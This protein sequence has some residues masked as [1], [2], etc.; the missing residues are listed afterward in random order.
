[1]SMS[2]GV[3]GGVFAT[4]ADLQASKP[5]VNTR[6]ELVSGVAYSIDSSDGGANL[7]VNGLFANPIPPI[8]PEHFGST[9]DGVADDGAA[10]QSA[11]G[12]S[13]E[14]EFNKTYFVGNTAGLTVSSNSSIKG[15]GTLKTNSFDANR[16]IF[17]LSSNNDISISGLSF[18]SLRNGDTIAVDNTAI[19]G[20]GCSNLNIKNITIENFGYYG[21]HLE[22]ATDCRLDRS[23]ITNVGRAG[24]LGLGNTRCHVHNNFIKDVSPGS[25]GVAPFIN[26]FGIVFS[27]TESSGETRSTFCSAIGN[28]IENVD[29]WEGIDIHGSTDILI[30][31]NTII[32]CAIGFFCG[33][34]TGTANLPPERVKMIG[35]TINNTSNSV[36]RAGF[37][38][39]ATPD[40]G[41]TIGKDFIVSDNYIEGYGTH[42]TAETQE[43]AIDIGFARDVEVSGN[44]MVSNRYSHIRLKE[45]VINCSITSNTF[46]RGVVVNGQSWVLNAQNSAEVEATF[47]NNSAYRE[48]GTLNGIWIQAAPSNETIYGIK[49]GSNRFIDLSADFETNAVS[50]MH[51][52][53]EIFTLTTT[54]AK[55]ESTGTI[56]N[57]V[58]VTSVNKSATGVYDVTLTKPYLSANDMNCVASGVGNNARIANATPTAA[59]T[60]TVRMFDAAGALTDN[61][62]QL[63]ASGKISK[64]P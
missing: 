42:D 13:G 6:V 53:S 7:P 51:S 2:N 18:E 45:D 49:V 20:D 63:N 56:R 40:A 41:V 35:N 24:Y 14:I 29:S 12:M 60:L 15:V 59:N 27:M 3:T 43:G 50:R 4:L 9:G 39:S 46:R 54:Q 62:F 23:S 31:R 8:T 64:M 17:D 28:H 25:G 26:R 10:C 33:S 19:R 37:L 32:N 57:S 38:I 16:G 1:M 11:L 21:V 5:R 55:I 48:G 30:E 61:E 22:N 58:N 47:T 36:S 34:A 44:N 52:Q